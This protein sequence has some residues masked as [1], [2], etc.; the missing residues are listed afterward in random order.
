MIRAGA[1]S[2]PS[3]VCL[4]VC[5]VNFLPCVNAVELASKNFT[6]HSQELLALAKPKNL[7]ESMQFG[8]RGELRLSAE[9]H[10]AQKSA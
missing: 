4:L 5:Y 8:L 9:V 10:L 2:F 3:R 6:E 1:R 7:D